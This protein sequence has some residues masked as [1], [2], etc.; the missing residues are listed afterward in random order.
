M[1]SYY[2]IGHFSRFIRPGAVRIIA[3][4]THDDLETTAFLN[5]DGRIALVVLNRTDNDIPFA[6]KHNNEAAETRSL[7]HSILTFIIEL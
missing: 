1:N 3:A 6:I 4:P 5:T 7:S 2:Y